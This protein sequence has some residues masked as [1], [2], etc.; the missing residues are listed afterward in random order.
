VLRPSSCS[1][2]PRA[3]SYRRSAVVS[4]R[5]HTPQEVADSALI[6]R[7]GHTTY[8]HEDNARILDIGI[9][10]YPSNIGLSLGRR[11]LS[12]VPLCEVGYLNWALH[13]L[14][15]VPRSI[16]SCS[17][18]IRHSPIKKSSAELKEHI[19]PWLPVKN[20]RLT[21]CNK[22][23]PPAL[24]SVLANRDFGS[25]NRRLQIHLV[26][27]RSNLR[28]VQDRSSVWSALPDPSYDPAGGPVLGPERQGE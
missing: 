1:P 13:S 20:G 11:I 6:V 27:Q 16:I 28:P 22:Q 15:P 26:T 3:R 2:S 21:W 7:A 18:D 25:N 5:S 10:R 12:T 19:Q 24:L 14:H 4:P 9:S 23:P 8:V 17:R